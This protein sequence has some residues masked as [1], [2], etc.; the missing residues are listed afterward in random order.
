MIMV[1]NMGNAF[2]NSNISGSCKIDK[3]NYGELIQLQVVN[4]SS[5]LSLSNSV[6]AITFIWYIG[7]IIIMVTSTNNKL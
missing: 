2:K 6:V 4:D 1:G 7:D 3:G 5:V